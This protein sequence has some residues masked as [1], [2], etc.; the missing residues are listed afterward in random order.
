MKKSFL[1]PLVAAVAALLLVAP[2]A[3]AGV[4]LKASAS[5]NLKLSV[6]PG[7]MY[8]V[9]KPAVPIVSPHRITLG[10]IRGGVVRTRVFGL[11]AGRV[12]FVGARARPFVVVGAP[13]AVV[14]PGA[15]VVVPGAA[16]ARPG[17]V[18]QSPAVVVG[19]P[20]VVVRPPTV[21]VGAPV[22]V[23]VKGKHDNGLHRGHHKGKRR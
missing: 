15:A 21:V 19:A 23:V 7:G 10:L 11:G 17:V 3:F 4:S 20:A 13:V 16:V 8:L 18:V 14:A 12:V 9:G 1:A 22:G 5:V 2:L 6:A